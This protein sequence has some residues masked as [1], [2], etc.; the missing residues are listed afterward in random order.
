MD[1][2]RIEIAAAPFGEVLSLA[3]ALDL[4]VVVAQLLVRRGLGDPAAASEFLSA[5][6]HY[7]P[8]EFAGIDK[9]VELALGHV[10]SG[11]TILI[12]GDYDVDGVCSTAILVRTL[13]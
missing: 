8:S 2:G 6:D 7:E 3:D 11:S 10:N 12:H 5:A 13:R 9:A 4:D 1:S